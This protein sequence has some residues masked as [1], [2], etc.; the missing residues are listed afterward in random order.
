M[1]PNSE[2]TTT[3]QPVLRLLQNLGWDEVL[4][5][6]KDTAGLQ[7]GAT[8][9]N[10]LDEV[11]LTK[12]LYSALQKINPNIP[13]VAIEAAVT[14]LQ[15]DRSAMSAIA[16]NQEI[17]KLIKDGFKTSYEDENR[18]RK[19]III[20]I[21]DW[22][23]RSNNSFVAINQFW[24]LGRLH[25]R[26][27]D[28]I[29]FINGLPLIHIE[30]KAP[31]ESADKAFNDNLRDYRDTI[32]QLFWYNQFIMISNGIDTKLGSMTATLEHFNEWKRIE[33]EDEVGRVSLET[34]IR[35]T[36]SPE[37][38]L[39]IIENFV[40]FTV[41]DDGKPAKII[42]KNHQYIGVNNAINALKAGEGGKLG[43]FWH[44]QGSGKSFSMMFFCP[45]NHAQAAWQLDIRNC[46]R[47]ARPRPADL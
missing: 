8:G 18:N 32:P 42:A 46:H 25:K 12:Y 15:R 21:I 9:R 2:D 4:N 47:S 5:G 43:V 7:D 16:A 27:P 30:L 44:T 36:C 33:S 37:R 22:D 26:R 45:E 10:T 29:G 31:G 3:E 40:L 6:F 14:E 13:G 41:G 17:Y 1:N 20:C 34:A 11:V 28:I 19:D 35:A 39:D 38:A 24:V 23:N